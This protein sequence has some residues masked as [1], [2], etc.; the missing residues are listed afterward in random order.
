MRELSIGQRITAD[1]SR[2][3]P[4]PELFGHPLEPVIVVGAH[5]PELAAFQ[6]ADFFDGQP[7]DTAQPD[8]LGSRRINLTEPLENDFHSQAQ[9]RVDPGR[10]RIRQKLGY[11][12]GWD[13]LPRELDP[14]AVDQDLLHGSRRDAKEVFFSKDSRSQ[15]AQF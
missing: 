6:L 7:L 2:S 3:A 1:R 10:A 4:A 13:S 11:E 14:R 8:N 15:P 9:F 5:S 12:L